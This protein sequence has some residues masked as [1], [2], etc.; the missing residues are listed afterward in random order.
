MSLDETYAEMRNFEKALIDFNE[1]L[2]A[3]L[4]EL[5][6][7]HDKVS[8]IWNDQMRKKYDAIWGPFL[9]TMKHYSV[10]E[11]PGYVEFL[12][13]KLHALRRYLHGD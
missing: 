11:G 1:R 2:R 10:S 8:P 13:I 9:Q 4:A 5:E 12:N 3:S 6:A 7:Q